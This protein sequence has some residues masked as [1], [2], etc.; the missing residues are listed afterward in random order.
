[1]LS[2][3]RDALRTEGTVSL[4]DLARRVDAAPDVVRGMLEHLIRRGDVGL[5]PATCGDCVQCD[6]ATTELYCWLGT[7][8]VRSA[9]R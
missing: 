9:G 2:V 5:V 1:M 8:R 4:A 6:T 3:I 7:D